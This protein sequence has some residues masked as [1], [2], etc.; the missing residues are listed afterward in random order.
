VVTGVRSVTR[1]NASTHKCLN[2]TMSGHFHKP[3]RTSPSPLTI[4][5]AHLPQE[6]FTCLGV[7][8]GSVVLTKLASLF[9]VT[10]SW[11]PHPGRTTVGKRRESVV[12]RN[13]SDPQCRSAKA[14][15]NSATLFLAIRRNPASRSEGPQSFWCVETTTVF[16]GSSSRINI[17]HWPNNQKSSGASSVSPGET[18]QATT[19]ASLGPHGFI[20]TSRHGTDRFLEASL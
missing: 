2:T 11:Q 19:D 12:L 20:L 17:N 18:P 14:F 9:V 10:A 15:T 7:S 8:S 13:Q 4:I 3:Q 16:A 1:T 6:G 5:N